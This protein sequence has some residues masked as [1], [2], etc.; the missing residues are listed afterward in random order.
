MFSRGEMTV[1]D[2][3]GEREAAAGRKKHGSRWL[4]IPQA[5]LQHRCRELSCDRQLAIL[6]DTGPR[7]YETQVLLDS[8]GITN[9]RIIQGGYAMIRE[10]E[11]DFV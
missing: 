5:E 1:L 6:C 2:V 3:R 11:P 4:H 9:T 10:I 8:V 7:A